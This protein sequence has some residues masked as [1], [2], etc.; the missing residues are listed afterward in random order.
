MFI[1]LIVMGVYIYLQIHQAFYIDYVQLFT[2]YSCFNQVGFFNKIF[3][4]I[5]K[6]GK[7]TYLGPKR[8]IECTSLR[9]QYIFSLLELY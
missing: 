3:F 4:S 5:E 6:K 9:H 2:C 8:N 1:V 7:Y